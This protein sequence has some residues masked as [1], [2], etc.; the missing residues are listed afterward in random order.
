MSTKRDRAINYLYWYFKT[1]F[2]KAGFCW[3]ESNDSD[4][5]CLIDLIIDAAAEASLAKLSSIIVR[6]EE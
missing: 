2:T 6:K 1:L 4:I 5:E 3:D